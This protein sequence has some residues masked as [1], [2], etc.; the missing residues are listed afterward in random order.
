MDAF[1]KVRMTLDFYQF[2]VQQSDLLSD[3]EYFQKYDP[4][5]PNLEMDSQESLV[6]TGLM[7]FQNQLPY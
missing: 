7:E 6:F 3:H 1:L 5:I 4:Q 2:R